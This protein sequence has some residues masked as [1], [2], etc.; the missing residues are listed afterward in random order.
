[1]VHSTQRRMISGPFDHF[2]TPTPDHLDQF[3]LHRTFALTGDKSTRIPKEFARRIRAQEI[4]RLVIHILLPYDR[5]LFAH[6]DVMFIVLS[7]SESTPQP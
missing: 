2:T 7:L 1:M 5:E 3:V 4:R 6:T